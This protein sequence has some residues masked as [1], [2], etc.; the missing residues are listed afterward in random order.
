MLQTATQKLKDQSAQND[1][2]TVGN[3]IQNPNLLRIYG[4]NQRMLVLF[5]D[6]YWLRVLALIFV[7]IFQELPLGSMRQWR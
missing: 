1:H 6:Q 3:L 7:V 4:T 2:N 5:E